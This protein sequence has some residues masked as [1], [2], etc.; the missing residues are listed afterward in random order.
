M[1][2]R[3]LP[4][5]T[6]RGILLCMPHD[7]HDEWEANRKA[8]HDEVKARHLHKKTAKED[9]SPDVPP[10]PPEEP[11]KK[12]SDDDSADRFSAGIY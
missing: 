6:S 5:F 12:A 4:R 7:E 8:H 3:S 2:Q 9:A 1:R 10:P 11:K